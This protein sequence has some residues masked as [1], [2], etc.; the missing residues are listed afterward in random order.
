MIKHH[1]EVTKLLAKLRDYMDKIALE[2]LTVR[3]PIPTTSTHRE[4][5]ILNIL[6]DDDD[7]AESSYTILSINV[8]FI[9]L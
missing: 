9:W 2:L 8:S 7:P 5:N 1:E 4:E 6:E 3:E